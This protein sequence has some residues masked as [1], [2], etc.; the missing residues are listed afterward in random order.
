LLVGAYVT[1][2]QLANSREQLREQITHNREQLQIAQRGHITERFTR[3]IDQLGHAQL[4]VRLGGIYALERIARGAHL[5]QAELSDAHL[6]QAWLSNANLENALL[7]R[8]NLEGARLIHTNLE[9][10]YLDHANL[11]E[12][13]LLLGA[14]L[15]AANLDRAILSGA[16]PKGREPR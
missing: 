4:D 5:K 10:T 16:D 8:A 15:E 11:L 3:A 1:Y 14:R 12:D 9:R 7:G 2:Q 13:A 6:T